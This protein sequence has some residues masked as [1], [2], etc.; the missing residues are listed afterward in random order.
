MVDTL[1]LF[2][3]GGSSCS[4]SSHPPTSSDLHNQL[5]LSHARTFVSLQHGSLMLSVSVKQ[6][7]SVL[8]FTHYED[9]SHSG[10]RYKW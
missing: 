4:R 9:I 6:R 10:W 7:H 8:L 3:E 2:H 1:E 5:M